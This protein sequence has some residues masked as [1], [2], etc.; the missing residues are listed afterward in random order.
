MDNQNYTVEKS[1]SCKARAHLGNSG[2]IPAAEN[3]WPRLVT[4]FLPIWHFLPLSV[5]QQMTSFGIV[6]EDVPWVNEQEHYPG[7]W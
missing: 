5:R 4:L 3:S 6:H 2:S 7:T 1:Y